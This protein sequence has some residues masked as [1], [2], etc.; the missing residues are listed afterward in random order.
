MN[1]SFKIELFTLTLIFIVNFYFLYKS[2]V[3][4]VTC[5]WD[6]IVICF[7]ILIIS[8][9]SGALLKYIFDIPYP[10][11]VILGSIVGIIFFYFKL[12]GTKIV[13]GKI[14]KEKVA[15]EKPKSEKEEL[16]EKIGEAAIGAYF[17]A[18]VTFGWAYFAMKEGLLLSIIDPIIISLL[19]YWIYSRYS[20]YATAIMTA[21]FIV[22]K[23]M[24]LIPMYEAGYS[25]G[26]G[27]GGFVIFGY[28]FIRGTYAAFLYNFDKT[29]KR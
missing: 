3:K 5:T 26:A 24:F 21:Y 12:K 10:M 14:K 22:G 11:P 8:L 7:Y 15:K 19:G 25:G 28:L 29:I 16:K 23:L 27:I 20:F 4:I 1:L 2:K 13:K 6:S 17:V 9:I 18:I